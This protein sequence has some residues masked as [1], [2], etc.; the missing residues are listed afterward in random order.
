MCMKSSGFEGTK[1]SSF[2]ISTSL[3]SWQISKKN[4]FYGL[5]IKGFGIKMA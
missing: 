1:T 3:P 2:L 5:Q 4:H